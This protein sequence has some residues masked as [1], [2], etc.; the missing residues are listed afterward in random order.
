MR[1]TGTG[2]GDAEPPELEDIEYQILDRRGRP[3]PWLA[4]KLT[5]DDDIRL[6]DEY[7]AA[8]FAERYGK[9]F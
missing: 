8:C 6:M 2:F 7:K 4:K 5:Q 1:I 3:A 9:A